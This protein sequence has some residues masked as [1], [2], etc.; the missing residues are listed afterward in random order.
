MTKIRFR[1]RINPW[2]MALFGMALLILGACGLK[3]MPTSDQWYMQHY[4][5][6][7][8]FERDAYK[9]LPTEKKAEFQ[10]LFW[11]ARSPE[12]K[13]EF[14]K[15]M[16]Y[17]M[18]TFKRE[19]SANPWNTDRARIYLLNGSPASIEFKQTDDW[20]IS[21]TR[22]AGETGSANDRS[23]ENIQARTGEGWASQY[24]QAIIYYVFTFSAPKRWELQQTS[25]EG[26]RYLGELEK[27]NREK[28]YGIIDSLKYAQA[29]EK[30]K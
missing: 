7:Q 8:D 14:D 29:L 16:E 30:L 21:M 2:S 23:N 6:M 24:D 19:N 4:M 15:R 5:I 27:L 26:N 22:N 10:S 9:E 20:G 25:F 11:E 18:K 13:M 17:V 12:S 3:L 28:Y 1:C